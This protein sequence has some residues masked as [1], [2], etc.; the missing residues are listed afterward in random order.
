M[1]RQ[2]LERIPRYIQAVFDMLAL[3]WRAQPFIFL[4]LLL[5]T[6]MQGL[7][8]LATA[9]LTKLLFDLLA[10]GLLDGLTSGLAYD[11]AIILT[12][13]ASLMVVSQMTAPANQFLSAEL[14]R[15]LTVSIQT[16][17]YQKISN[18][19]GI[20]YFENPAFHDTFRLA[21][22][23]AQLGPLH[24]LQDV[25]T[26]FQSLI[27]LGGF[28]GI[29]V[30]FDPLLAAMVGLAA[31]PQLYAQ[32]RI[33]YQR[34]GLAF[35]LSPDERRVFYYGHLLSS[36]QAAKEIRL[37]NLID[38]LLN[39]LLT[40]YHKIH[41]AQRHQ[42]LSELRWKLFL[43]ALSTLVSSAAFVVVVL[44]AFA[45][46][47]SLGDVTLYT[48]AVRSIQSALSGIVYS[49]SALNEQALFFTHY[50][51]LKAL[52]QPVRIANPAQ[53]VPTLVSGIEFQNVSFRYSEKHPWVLQDVSFFIPSG[54]CLA[55]VGANGAGKTTLVKLLT[56]LYDP[57]KGRILWDGMDIREFDL[58]DLR[59]RMGVIFQDFMQY[60]FTAQENIGLGD[61]RYIEDVPRIHRAAEKAGVH[62]TIKGLPQGYQ[63][64]LSRMFGGNGSGMDLS[65]GEWQKIAVARMFM[66]QD[67]ELLILDEPTAALDAQAEYEIYD[68]FVFLVEGRTSLLISHRFSTVR[69]AD[70]IA[71][72]QDGHVT[73][74]GSHEELLSHG[75]TY[76]RL[77][78]M[79]AE[80]YQ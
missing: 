26:L 23:G 53:P 25:T 56:R 24:S 19:A 9:W 29:L 16:S 22:Q 2:W 47:L 27:T 40:T 68:R 18:F 54:Q 59:H 39:G 67:A 31:L 72:L 79:Q 77:Y 28:I 13:Q 21:V 75:R 30:A 12:G 64:T 65:G 52:P 5:L 50:Q 4:A 33:G 63:T 48:N 58:A 37:F 46:R 11:L 80:R 6:A 10:V 8:P 61:V 20:A 35:D 55:L 49:L 41:Q 73:E 71:V 57:T 1:I 62:D 14:G 66:R 76:A 15:R 3:A 69:M 51:N 44:Q 43:E 32:L 60:D 70:A 74:Y 7:L 38:Y 42:E 34:F 78:K 45:G 17:I 36:P